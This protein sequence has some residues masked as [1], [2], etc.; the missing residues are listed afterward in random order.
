MMT[1][2][3]RM[4]RVTP[5]I[6]MT[7][8]PSRRWLLAPALALCAASA[9]AQPAPAPA[10]AA[11]AAEPAAPPAP[12]PVKRATALVAKVTL[13]VVHPDEVRRGLMAAA[14]PLGGFPVLVEDRRLILH[15]PPSKLPA[16]VDAV[17]AAG[18]VMEKTLERADLTGEIAQLEA[19]LRSK[20]SIF[21]RLRRLVD[22]A[23]TQA[24]LRIERSMSE[25][26]AEME[27]I[28]G[29]LRVERARARYAVVDVSFEF[30]ERQRIVY[31]RSPFEWL[32]TVDLGQFDARF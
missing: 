32:N 7:A 21:A 2:M 15:V 18:L 25:L 4:T 9:G 13:K 14:E 29:R 22:D 3:T 28:A 23:D 1:R 11:V 5:V 20:Q 10:P 19:L 31:V 26:V 12:A 27:G 6:R 8:M 30:R 16:M 17:T 24:T